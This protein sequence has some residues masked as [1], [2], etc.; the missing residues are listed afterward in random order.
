MHELSPSFFPGFQ[1]SIFAALLL[2][3]WALPAGA[4]FLTALH[5]K[6]HARSAMHPRLA[7]QLHGF[8]SGSESLRLAACYLFYFGLA[9]ASAQFLDSGHMYAVVAFAVISALATIFLTGG[10]FAARKGKAGTGAGMAGVGCLINIAAVAFLLSLWGPVFLSPAAPGQ[11][12]LSIF[13]AFA[14]ISAWQP[15]LWALFAWLLLLCPALGAACGQVWVLFKRRRDDFGR[16]YY[17]F[18][19]KSC[20]R[21]GRLSAIISLIPAFFAIWTL[22]IQPLAATAASEA[23][24]PVAGVNALHANI[25]AAAGLLLP[26]IAALLW[27]RVARSATPLRHKVALLLCPVLLLCSIWCT[28]TALLYGVRQAAQLFG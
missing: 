11:A 20:A 3:F 22:S 21:V 27:T 12:A 24:L 28:C 18:A 5:L 16:D 1:A 15:P 9:T 7:L 19:L 23:G 10:I 2:F 8:A 14:G 25:W 17:S 6:C 13:D 4:A 26:L